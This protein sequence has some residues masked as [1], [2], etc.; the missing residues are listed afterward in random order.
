MTDTSLIAALQEGPGSPE[1]DKR[2]LEGLGWWQNT[3]TNLPVDPWIMPDGERFPWDGP[4]PSP[5][6]N[7]GDVL[8]LVPKG[9]WID[10]HVQEEPDNTWSALF[11]IGTKPSASGSGYITGFKTPEEARAAIARAGCIAILEVHKNAMNEAKDYR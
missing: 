10:I 3:N 4:Q 8:A 5:S 11:D 2:V 7:E 9:H 6:E 1:N